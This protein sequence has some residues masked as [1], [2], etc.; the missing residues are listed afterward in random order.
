MHFKNLEC[1]M[2]WYLYNLIRYHT[3]EVRAGL[4]TRAGQWTRPRNI[5]SFQMNQDIHLLFSV[6]SHKVLS[7]MTQ[8]LESFRL[9]HLN[10]VLFWYTCSLCWKLSCKMR[11]VLFQKGFLGVFKYTESGLSEVTSLKSPLLSSY[12]FK[13][14][15][16]EKI[17]VRGLDR[18]R[19]YFSHKMFLYHFYR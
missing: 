18:D 6:K 8:R 4:V 9:S 3:N 2:T 19:K 7:L 11:Y 13:H 12:G 5:Y 16:K 1:D 10:E 14:F 17:Y 15:R